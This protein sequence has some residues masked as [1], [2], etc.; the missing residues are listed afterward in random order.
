MKLLITFLYILSD[1]FGY[2]IYFSYLSGGVYIKKSAHGSDNQYGYVKMWVI[3]GNKRLVY[4]DIF[5]YISSVRVRE[6]KDMITILLM[7]GLLMG[8]IYL[9]KDILKEIL[10]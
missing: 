1:I 2:F 6:M 4:V 10:L 5:A 8:P 9:W 7:M 3:L